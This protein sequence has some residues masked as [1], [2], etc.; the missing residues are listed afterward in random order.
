M[1]DP[2]GQSAFFSYYV[3]DDGAIIEIEYVNG[4]WHHDHSSP[5]RTTN[6]TSIASGADSPIAAVAYTL[7]GNTQYVSRF[8]KIPHWQG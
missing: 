8:G 5:P 7:Q 4:N 1:L 6:I 3:D 2:S